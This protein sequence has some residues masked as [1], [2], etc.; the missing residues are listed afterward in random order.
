M[1]KE[2]VG[3]MWKGQALK[4][5]EGWIVASLLKGWRYWVAGTL[6]RPPVCG[7]QGMCCAVKNKIGQSIFFFSEILSREVL[8]N[9]L[10]Q[11]QSI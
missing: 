4:E 9:D 5:I 6:F 10:L 2:E 7:I 11:N 1:T 8:M 3:T